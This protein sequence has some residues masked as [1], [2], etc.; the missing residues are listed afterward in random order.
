MTITTKDI[1]KIQCKI[2]FD[3]WYELTKQKFKNM[4]DLEEELICKYFNEK[5]HMGENICRNL[6]EYL[7]DWFD[8]YSKDKLFEYLWDSDTS[9]T[10]ILIVL[11][12]LGNCY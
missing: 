1:D 6:I 4:D 7:K 12:I 5:Y 2:F 11:F 9:F 8:R 10:I 3:C